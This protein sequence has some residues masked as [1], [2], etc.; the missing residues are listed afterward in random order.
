MPNRG[1]D[2]TVIGSASDERAWTFPQRAAS[3]CVLTVGGLVLAVFVYGNF[4]LLNPLIQRLKAGIAQVGSFVLRGRGVGMDPTNNGDTLG[5]WCALAGCVIAGA[6]AAAVW[7]VAGRH[8]ADYRRS[9][10]ALF[11]VARVGLAVELF[12][13][14]LAKVIPV[15]MGYMTQPAHQLSLT[16][17]L[18]LKDTLW[19]FMGASDPYSIATGLAELTAGALLLWRRTVPAG[20]LLAAIAMAQVFLLNLCYDVPVKI[21]SGTLLAT[22]IAIAVPYLPNLIRALTNTAPLPPRPIW[23]A[24]GSKRLRT[25][26]AILG[27]VAVVA[28]TTILAVL[29]GSAL[30]DIHTPRSDLDGVWQAVSFTIDGTPATSSGR[31]PEPWSNVAIT[32]RT[33]Y[34]SFVSQ[35]P[36]GATT[37][38]ALQ[39]QDGKLL[40]R[41]RL[42]DPPTEIRYRWTDPATL[43]LSGA[44]G[45]HFI[46]AQFQRRAMHREESGFRLIQP[47]H[48][49]ELPNK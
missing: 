17:D 3:R 8:R 15:Q 25:G 27:S 26:A 13:Y 28:N 31:D 14:G 34:E 21:V 39:K 23:P 22:A 9:L 37:M 48:D 30:V 2:S 5:E 24:P 46:E 33:D 41:Q 42:S 29:F 44:F 12:A 18:G 11:E 10:R 1:S 38:W 43:V 16:G 49:P 20:S 36:S 35:T 4:V 45:D 6:A 32:D 19:T 7:S 47:T 40:I